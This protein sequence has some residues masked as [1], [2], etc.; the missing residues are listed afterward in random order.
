MLEELEMYAIELPKFT[1][2]DLNNMTK[3]EEWITYL[4]GC[5]NKVL[6]KIKNNNK[7]IAL[8]D[9]LAEKYWLEEKME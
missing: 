8:L 1:I 2:E 4:K 5:E 6:E 3:K 9:K 7:N